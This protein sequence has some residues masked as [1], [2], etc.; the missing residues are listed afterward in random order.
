MLYFVEKIDSVKGTEWVS[1]VPKELPIFSVYG[2]EDP[3]GLYGIGPNETA[4]W[5][6]KTDHR[7][8]NKTCKG[9]C[10]EVHN[11]P[12]TRDDVEQSVRSVF[13]FVL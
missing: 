11:Y 1:Q 6:V 8:K 5:L 12:D 3:S 2:N 4:G 7:V 13:D 9:K 10:H